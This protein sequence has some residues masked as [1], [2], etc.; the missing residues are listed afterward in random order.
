[1]QMHLTFTHEPPVGFFLENYGIDMNYSSL[2]LVPIPV[3]FL[4]L[5]T[6]I[7]AQVYCIRLLCTE[8]TVCRR[9]NDHFYNAGEEL[10]WEI[11]HEIRD[12]GCQDKPRS[13]FVH[14]L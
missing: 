10:I 5:C 7:F 13:H 1:M 4:P 8:V 6:P 2:R 14:C 12:I 3:K 11:A 9:K